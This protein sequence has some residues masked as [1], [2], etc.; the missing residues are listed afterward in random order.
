MYRLASKGLI[1][2]PCGVP[3]VFPFPPL[4][5]GFP[6][7]S[8][9][10]TGKAVLAYCTDA[11]WMASALFLTQI[12]TTYR[13]SPSPKQTAACYSQNSMPNEHIIALLIAERDKLNR[14][15]EALQG[16]AKR[17]GRP[18]KNPMAAAATPII[19]IAPKK[20]KRKRSAAQR[21]AQADRMKAYWT[22]K[23]KKTKT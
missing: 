18:T 13:K 1:T 15:I 14:A 17:R 16:S 3:Q 4:T 20:K 21:K 6:F 11:S 7:P 2:P 9:S 10:S 23:R 22:A 12:N 19:A 5:R 8:R